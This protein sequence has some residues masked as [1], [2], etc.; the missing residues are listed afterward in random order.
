MGPHQVL[1][2]QARC[3]AWGTYVVP[4]IDALGGYR[5]SSRWSAARGRS[6]ATATGAVLAERILRLL[7]G[8]LAVPRFLMTVWVMRLEVADGPGELD[9]NTLRKVAA[10]ARS[11]DSEG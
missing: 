1:P 6:I 3:F 8:R 4:K 7:P 9:L 2:C 11:A 10:R 5:A